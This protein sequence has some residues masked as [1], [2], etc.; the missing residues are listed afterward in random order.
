[1]DGCGSE[2]EDLSEVIRI[3]DSPRFSHLSE[4]RPIDHRPA[5]STRVAGRYERNDCREDETKRRAGRQTGCLKPRYVGKLV[6]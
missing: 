1:M 3:A 4:L 2:K 6:Y 5:D